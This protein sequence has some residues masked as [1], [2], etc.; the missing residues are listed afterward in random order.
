MRTNNVF[1]YF[2]QTLPVV[3][4]ADTLLKGKHKW[5]KRNMRI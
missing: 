4:R 3:P 1:E 2:H 5:L